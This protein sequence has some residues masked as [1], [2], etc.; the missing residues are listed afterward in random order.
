MLN[1]L[2]H[3]TLTA[4]KFV[5]ICFEFSIFA[6]HIA[7]SFLEITQEAVIQDQAKTISPFIKTSIFTF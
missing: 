1:E 3:I 6:I 4:S 7:I 2:V 5:K